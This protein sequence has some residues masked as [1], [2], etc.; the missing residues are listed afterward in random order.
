MP[1]GMRKGKLRFERKVK[2]GEASHVC[3]AQGGVICKHLYEGTAT[4][5]VPFSRD[6]APLLLC[7]DVPD[8]HCF[9]LCPECVIRLGESTLFAH[10]LR[11]VCRKCCRALR[12]RAA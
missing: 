1:R 6:G 4:V 10:D 8:D 9:F 11:A 2:T 12:R 5:W 3:S 7:N